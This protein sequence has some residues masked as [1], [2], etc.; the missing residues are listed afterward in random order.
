MHFGA[1]SAAIPL[2]LLFSLELLGT[3]NIARAIRGN[4]ILGL[5]HI[6]VVATKDILEPAT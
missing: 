2:R 3:E 1:A 5:R 4:A 6:V